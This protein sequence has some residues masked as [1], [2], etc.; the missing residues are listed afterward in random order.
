MTA[1]MNAP[2]FFSRAISLTSPNK[3]A[4]K[5]D[6]KIEKKNDKSTTRTNKHQ[7]ININK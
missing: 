7:Q 1:A 3:L 6:I 5:R 4:S 2:F